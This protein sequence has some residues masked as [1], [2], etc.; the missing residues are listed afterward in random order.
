MSPPV[1][2]QTRE[3]GIRMALGEAAARVQLRVLSHAMQLGTLGVT[4]GAV[5]AVAGHPRRVARFLSL[6]P[7]S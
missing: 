2:R 7:S 6:V 4:L 1:G 3:I 5:L